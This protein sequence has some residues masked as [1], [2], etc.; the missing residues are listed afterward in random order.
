M[1]PSVKGWKNGWKSF[2]EVLLP[3]QEDFP[4]VIALMRYLVGMVS[5]DHRRGQASSIVGEELKEWISGETAQRRSEQTN[6]VLFIPIL[7]ENYCLGSCLKIAE[8]INKADS[9]IPIYLAKP[10]GKAAELPSYVE[11]VDFAFLRK[12]SWS[13]LLRAFFMSITYWRAVCR[14]L[15]REKILCAEMA[16]VYGNWKMHL[17]RWILLYHYDER[18]AAKFLTQKSI[19]SV[20]TIND[21]VKPAAPVVSAGNK[22]GIRSVVLQH[23]TP[24]PQSAP[25]LANQGWVWGETSRQA[26]VT[27][28]ADPDRLKIIGNLEGEFLRSK[29]IRKTN[30]PRV[31][32]FLAQWRATRGWGEPFFQEV[33]NLLREVL[34]KCPGRWKLRVR[35][36]PTDPA[37]AKSDIAAR[38]DHPTVSV[39]FA[40][41]GVSM[42]NELSEVDALLSVN[43]SGLM[44]GVSANL[45]TA[46]ILPRALEQVVGPALLN[47]ENLLRN[48]KELEQWFSRIESDDSLIL[49]STSK[50]LANRGKVATLM[51]GELITFL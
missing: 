9:K 20:V 8:E 6:G 42:S 51:A 44:N 28:G 39:E 50:V 13:K 19:A 23:G 48:G 35:L 17:F 21:V 25:F 26:L 30:E 32:L 36:H 45:P 7:S 43:S 33:F 41:K 31:L 10:A 1:H 2:G 37:E 40:T 49:S 5:T 3:L 16:R 22:Q 27:F 24:G 11:L 29:G 47:A 38:L 14:V 18:I 12:K 4:Q 34:V 15:S 46:Q